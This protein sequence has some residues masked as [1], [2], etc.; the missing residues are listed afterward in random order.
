MTFLLTRTT[1]FLKAKNTRNRLTHPRTYYD[2]EISE[3]E[4]KQMAIT[5]KWMKDGFASIMKEK[6]KVI[7]ETLPKEFVNTYRIQQL[8]EYCS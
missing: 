2:I 5:F 3:E 7:F 6:I 1:R 8:K 4:I